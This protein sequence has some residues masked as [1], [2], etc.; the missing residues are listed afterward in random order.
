MITLGKRGDM[1]AHQKASGFLLKPEVIPKLFTSFA[2]RYATR[3]GGYT[4]IHKYGNRPGDNAPVALLEL[5]D[6]PH[7]VRFAMTARTVGRETLALKLQDA[8]LRTVLSEGLPEM[9]QV[10]ERERALP[11]DAHGL[12]NLKTRMNLQKVLQ[13]RGQDAAEELVKE[14]QA[15]TVRLTL[16]SLRV[17]VADVV[18]YACRVGFSNGPYAL[19]SS[20]VRN[21]PWHLLMFPP[22]GELA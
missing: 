1:L 2:Q 5:V 8:P 22:K 10:V 20:S 16:N 11:I 21:R 9:A 19:C 18:S 3:P 17:V 7:D 12:L 14:A 13:F 15:H 4:R 6:A